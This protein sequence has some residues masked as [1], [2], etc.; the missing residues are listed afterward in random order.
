MVLKNVP[1]DLYN[2]KNKTII[3]DTYCKEYLMYITW[4]YKLNGILY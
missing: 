3:K 4:E 1:K 2:T